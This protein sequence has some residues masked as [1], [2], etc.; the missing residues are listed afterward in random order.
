MKYI[1]IAHSHTLCLSDLGT[2]GYLHLNH[3]N[4]LILTTRNFQ[5]SY[6]PCDITVK[7]ATSFVTDC[8]SAYIEPCHSLRA[9]KI[10]SVDQ[11]I[12]NWCHEQYELFLPHMCD[13]YAMLLATHKFCKKVS[14]VQEG[15]FSRQGSFDVNIPFYKVIFDKLKTYRI[16]HTLRFYGLN[17]YVKGQLPRQ[18]EINTYAVDTS[19]FQYL[20]S[21][22]HAIRWPSV[23]S[24]VEIDSGGVYFM[25]EGYTKNGMAEPD[26]YM[27][28]CDKM[29]EQF[30]GERNYVKFHPNQSE[31]EISLI[32][33][34]FKSRG[35]HYKVIPKGIPFEL[36][37]SSIN[38]LTIIGMSTS[39]LY[40]AKKQ[41]H[42]VV[43][44]DSWMMESPL[45]RKI[46]EEGLPLFH[47]YFTD[48]LPTHKL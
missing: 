25:M 6:I 19:F 38:K 32:C 20:P 22:C 3:S 9:T 2:I 21:R 33:S 44:C 7:D 16:F 8:Q 39:L 4:V 36:Y 26:V 24:H 27:K 12:T 23:E 29:I 28:N 37:L 42:H 41:G 47:E 35:Y 30:H 5:C 14:F 1:F 13:A 10:Q 18:K 15:A 11:C 34:F 40:F 17:W 31:E 45:F 43:S 46:H 48:E